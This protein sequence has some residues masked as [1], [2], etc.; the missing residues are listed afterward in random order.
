MKLS[1]TY[2]GPID[3]N[4]GFLCISAH[5]RP[6]PNDPDPEMPGQKL[7]M[8][9]FILAQPR[10]LCLCGSGKRYGEC[11][12][13]RRYWL[14]ICPNPGLQG[15][16][17]LAP[18]SATFKDVDGHALHERLMADIRLQCVEDRIGQGFWI[19]WGDPALD[20]SYGTLCFGDLELKPDHILLAT[21]MSDVRM[22]TLLD[23]LDEIAADLL[24]SPKMQYDKVEALDKVTGKRLKLKLPG[25][26]P[27]PRRQ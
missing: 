23:L 18:Q 6:N 27:T 15:Y 17:L 11:C 7:S 9:S 25:R 12:R 21:A 14:P 22:R 13:R 1:A 3:P 2:Q 10:D 4:S 5:W 8:A 26:A 20:D 16:S 24:P 19:Y